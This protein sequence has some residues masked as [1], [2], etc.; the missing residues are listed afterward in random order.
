MRQIALFPALLA[1]LTPFA[2][3]D[4]EGKTTP[5]GGTNEGAALDGG[6]DTGPQRTKLQGAIDRL[7]MDGMTAC[8]DGLQELLDNCR[9][10]VET[11][12]ANNDAAASTASDRKEGLSESEGM[13]VNPRYL[14]GNADVLKCLL[15]HEWVHI[16]D[17]MP[18]DREKRAYCAEVDCLA[19]ITNPSGRVIA[20]LRFT[21]G[22]KNRLSFDPK[23]AFTSSGPMPLYSSALLDGGDSVAYVFADTPELTVYGDAGIDSVYPLSMTSPYEVI[24]IDGG[25]TPAVAVLGVN[26]AGDGVVEIVGVD[27]ALGTITGPLEKIELPGSPVTSAVSFKYLGL[28]AL[29][30]LDPVNDT[31]EL[32]L[33]LDGDNL[34]ETHFPTPW[35]T[36]AT[37]PSLATVNDIVMRDGSSPALFLAG[38]DLELLGELPGDNAQYDLIEDTN[39]DL[40]ADSISLRTGADEIAL[41]PGFADGA[42]YGET[43]IDIYGSSFALTELWDVDA[44]GQPTTLL[45]STTLGADRRGVI[46]IASPLAIG[47]RVMLVDQSGWI[48]V[49]PVAITVTAERRY[50]DGCQASTGSF[51][52]H[53]AYGSMSIGTSVRWGL[54]LGDAGTTSILVLSLSQANTP[55]D[56]LGAPGCTLLVGP[57]LLSETLVTN[58]HGEAV[59]TMTIPNDPNLVGLELFSQWAVSDTGNALG[60]VTSNAVALTLQP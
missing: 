12:T 30:A 3:A 10:C 32:L 57:T 29:W 17:G 44:A 50:G 7:R 47:Q 21:R 38:Q 58:V 6:M 16:N 13:N 43:S 35:A 8:A 1:T 14:N 18:N 24:Q 22:I 40:L 20:R 25:G 55:L 31:I 36:A 34:P 41:A 4:I 49:P 56:S 46:Q 48:S 59:H 27:P 9:L 54:D 23:N 37:F 51:P 28:Q 52:T 42:N 11:G 5:A 45:G 19:A 39:S 60:L 33:D 26:A 2:L 53:N 15:A